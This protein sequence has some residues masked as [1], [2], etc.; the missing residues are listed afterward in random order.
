M[1]GPAP[2]WP[3]PLPPPLPRLRLRPLPSAERER[4]L[5]RSWFGSLRGVAF[6]G[7]GARAATAAA[8]GLS[9]LRLT[10]YAQIGNGWGA[11]VQGAAEKLAAGFARKGARMG[12]MR[13]KW[14]P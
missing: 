9:P 2:S 3:L 14:F 6:G 7:E 13:P 8:L 4:F 5:L 10:W 12:Q 1:S 11:L